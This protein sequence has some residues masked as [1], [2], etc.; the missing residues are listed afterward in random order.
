MLKGLQR[1]QFEPYAIVP[2][3]TPETLE[4]VRPLF[5][6]MRLFRMPSWN[7][8][9]RMSIA[10]RAAI[11]L[12]EWRRG[13]TAGNH[14][15]KILHT[16]RDW[17]IDLV[18]TGTSLNACG[19]EA[20]LQAGIPHVWHIKE[21][22]GSGARVNFPL[23]DKELANYIS[24]MS[25]RVVVMSE[26][27]ARF[28]RRYDCRNLEVLPDGVDLVPYQSSNSRLLRG[29]LGLKEDQLLVGMVAS[30]ASTFK[31]HE[32]FIRM[33]GELA[34]ANTRAHFVL[35]GPQSS[36]RR[37]PHEL[38]RRYYEGLVRLARECVPFGRITFLDTLADPGDVMRSLDVLVHPC[39][40]EPFGRIAIESMAAGTP[41]VGSLTG[42]IAETITDGETGL[43]V[44]PKDPRAFA[45]ATQLLLNSSDLRA[46][47]G[48]A[49]KFRAATRYSIELHVER[50]AALYEQVMS[51]RQGH[52]SVSM[53]S[54][55]ATAMS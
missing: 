26:Y 23:P 33:A 50:Q 27:I 39:S 25:A 6:D 47:M 8:L 11:V 10:R 36:A 42:G 37:W 4:L 1:G 38:P 48:R 31:Q 3:G 35:L 19:A 45:E 53:K 40:V 43:L 28:F 51:E 52:S 18:H 20:A 14:T 49:G 13:I 44:K 21:C 29:L 2:P 55:V 24:R 5:A 46:R 34:K 30:L 9:P 17:K 7:T 16:I 41:V 54:L 32:V 22:V 12:G 15:R